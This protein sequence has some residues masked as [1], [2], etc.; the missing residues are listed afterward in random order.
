MIKPVISLFLTIMAFVPMYAYGFKLDPYSEHDQKSLKFRGN[1]L[2]DVIKSA[3]IHEDLTVK[4][5]AASRINNEYKSPEFLRGVIRGIRWN[6][7]PLSYAKVNPPTFYLSFVDSCDHPEDV[8]PSW[9]LLYR[10]HCGDM[11]FL[12]AMASTP[13]ETSETTRKKIMMW[14]EFSFKVASGEIDKD[15]R[16]RS[17]AEEYKLGP[18]TTQAFNE[19]M[20]NNGTTRLE[21]Q[22]EWLFTLDCGRWFT[23]KGLFFRGRLTELT[24]ADHNNKFTDQEI[25]DIALGS[26]LHLIQDS[27]SRSHVSRERSIGIESSA[28]SGVGRIIQF[29]NYLLQ[30]HEKHGKADLTVSDKDS[31]QE[32]DLTDISARL[33]EWIVQQRV[34]RQSRWQEAKEVLDKVFELADSSKVAGDIGF[35]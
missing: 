15:W 8:D 7:D 6:D 9:D 26:F 12:H 32:F 13:N 31:H 33:I 24:C 34:D 18:D 17:L 2:A 25:Q 28:V 21:W 30:D 11:Q 27:F 16:F 3:P 14:L 19:L 10:T 1:H 23:W 29:G 20:T 5:I 22:S 4:A 35:K